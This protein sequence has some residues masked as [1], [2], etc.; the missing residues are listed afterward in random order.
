[1]I[2]RKRKRIEEENKKL[3]PQ[4]EKNNLELAILPSVPQPTLQIEAPQPLLIEAPQPNLSNKVELD[5]KIKQ[6]N[7]KQKKM[8]SFFT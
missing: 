4:L 2:E 1:M 8:D 6:K 3:K 7:K 5:K